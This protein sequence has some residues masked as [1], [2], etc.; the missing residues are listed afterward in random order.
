MAEKRHQFKN[1]EKNHPVL[2]NVRPVF[3]TNFAGRVTNGNPQGRRVFC[4]RIDNSDDAELLHNSG[5]NV[6]TRFVRDDPDQV[7]FYF[8]EVEASYRNPTHD[9]AKDRLFMPKVMQITQSGVK[10]TLDEETIG[11]LDEM[12]ILK[13][14]LKLRP[15]NWFD[16]RDKTEHV[17]AYLEKAKILVEDD[18]FD[19]DTFGDDPVL[20]M[21]GSGTHVIDETAPSTMVYDED[22]PF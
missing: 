6:K 3:Q 13:M 21:S 7:D 19:D 15:Y 11:L 8:L 18:P 9:P 14:N 17:K 10:T 1:F 5:W 20:I 2:K 4:V 12:T 16:E 22:V